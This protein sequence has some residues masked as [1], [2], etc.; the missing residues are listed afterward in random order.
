VRKT[1]N[2][3]LGGGDV[4]LESEESMGKQTRSISRGRGRGGVWRGTRSQP[5]T[6]PM[7]SQV[8]EASF[9][10]PKFVMPP[11]SV[12]V[13][14]VCDV[15]LSLLTTSIGPCSVHSMWRLSAKIPVL[16]HEGSEEMCQVL[17]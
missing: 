10:E 14:N 1:S 3:S 13:S 5:V 17:P 11:N 16:H 6:T 9:Q 2:S 12:V 15:L 7:R 4:E 8:A